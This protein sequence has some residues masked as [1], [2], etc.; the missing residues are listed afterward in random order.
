MWVE[1]FDLGNLDVIGKIDKLNERMNDE[2]VQEFLEFGAKVNNDLK[3]EK[4]F[5]MR[6][7]GNGE[8][9]LMIDGNIYCT[10]EKVVI[11]HLEFAT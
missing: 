3:R 9:V 8:I 6:L 7:N 1:M 2:D 10:L 4:L 5:H 11:L